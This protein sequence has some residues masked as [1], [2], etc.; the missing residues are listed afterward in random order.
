MFAGFIDD[1]SETLEADLVTYDF[2]SSTFSSFDLE[3]FSVEQKG[4]AGAY[5]IVGLSQGES[6]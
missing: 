2:S 1:S 4:A 6:T 3:T 5:V